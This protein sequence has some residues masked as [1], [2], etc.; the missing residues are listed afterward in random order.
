MVRSFESGLSSLSLLEIV[1]GFG[2]LYR[3]LVSSSIAVTNPHPLASL[4]HPLPSGE[5][6][7]VPLLVSRM[8]ATHT[9]Y[10]YGYRYNRDARLPGLSISDSCSPP[11]PVPS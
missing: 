1:Q 5:G 8:T 2:L 6:I 10:L 4:A 11:S 9:G 7:R 3:G